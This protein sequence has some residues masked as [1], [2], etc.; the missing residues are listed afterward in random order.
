MLQLKKVFLEAHNI[1]NMYSG[2]GQFNYWLI[3]NLIDNNE[4]FELV[5][6]A[7]SRKSIKDFGDKVTFKKYYDLNRYKLFRPR[8]KYDLWHSLNQNSK[9]EPYRDLPYLL[10]FHDV[11]FMEK[12]KPEDRNPEK[13]QLLKE[14][15]NRCDAIAFI[16]EHARRSANNYFDIPSHIFQTVIYNGNPITAIETQLPQPKTSFPLKK[17]FLFCIGQ[18][19]EM[20]NFHS[21]V[22][23]LS[24]LPDYQ[25][26]LAGNNNKPYAEVVKQEIQKYGLEDR[27]F[28]SGKISEEEKHYYLKN[29]T[30]FLF[31]SL[32]EGFG[33][34]PIEAMAYGKPVFLAKRTSLP[35]IGGEY[36]FYWDEFEP[37]SMAAVFNSGIE[38]YRNNKE[39][40]EEQLKKR[41]SM[42]SWDT[43]AKEYI[44]LY[45]QLS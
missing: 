7:A 12:D 30:A 17:P 34:P 2:F 20:K 10:T 22:G 16:S 33:L 18:F 26:I 37:E 45:R 19:L 38:E 24:F 15:I 1:K 4:E 39:F 28:L 44:K 23:M 29:C 40:Y 31:P 3:K 42:F 36:A 8:G 35:E 25:L 21:L 32:F 6:N 9:I 41:G 14:K 13:I 11:I 5:V 27:I 43:T